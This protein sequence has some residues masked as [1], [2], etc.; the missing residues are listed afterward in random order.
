[1]LKV[2][3][4][5]K[6]STCR[7]ALKFLREHE[8]EFQEVPIRETPPTLAELKQVLAVKEGKVRALFN[9]SGLDYKAQGLSTKLPQLTEAE[10]LDL[11]AGNGNLVKRP[12]M[13]GEKVRL[14]GFH[15]GEWTT[16]LA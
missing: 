11:L 16:A 2:Y 13:V 9:T 3:T 4:Y 5:A 15:E 12:F 10:A 8:I 7:N 1:M 6:C 14:V